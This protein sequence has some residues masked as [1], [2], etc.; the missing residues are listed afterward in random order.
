M[1]WEKR[2]QEPRW[3]SVRRHDTTVCKS[4]VM[5]ASPEQSSCAA[6]TTIVG[7][8]AADQ[9]TGDYSWVNGLQQRLDNQ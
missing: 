1:R 2:D 5:D 9:N 3:T 4:L 7:R 8:E 6:S